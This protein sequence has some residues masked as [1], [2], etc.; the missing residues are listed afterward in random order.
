MINREMIRLKVVQLTYSF[1]QN[2]GKSLD[3]AEK[4]L[5]FSMSKAYE[6]Y[7]YL[8][9]L[10]VE[11]QKYAARRNEQRLAREQRSGAVSNNS[12]SPAALGNSSKLDCTHLHGN[13]TD[14]ILAGNKLLL[15]LRSNKALNEY[16]ENQKAAWD[17]E[18][19]L[20]KRL[21]S[22]FID[23]D[24]FGLYVDKADYSFAAD[25]ELI[26]KF[27][28]TYICDN[29]DIDSMLEDHSLYWNDD[30]EIIDSFV[31]KTIK[32]FTEESNEEMPL[33]PEFSS[34]DDR[35]FAQDLFHA[36]LTRD[37]EL[38]GFIRDNTRNWEFNRLAVMDVI[39]MQIAL[40]EILTFPTIPLSVTFNE[41][42]DIAKVYSTPKSASY[43][44]GML[45]GIVKNLHEQGIVNKTR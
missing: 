21:Y 24:I 45:D 17:E 5:N 14:Q 6:L 29:E 10:L 20:V 13:S 4:E 41:Y 44:N 37:A 31:L 22:D 30:K 8:L 26:R 3:V 36:T 23:S 11:I 42:L 34:D 18:E 38:R 33:L 27:Y 43:I 12:I 9:S 35:R 16:I 7:L 2:E 19:N 15:L 1:Y 40:A 39:I 32:R 28:K 25:R